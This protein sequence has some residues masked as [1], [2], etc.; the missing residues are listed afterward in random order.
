[1]KLDTLT[2]VKMITV[3]A[4]LILSGPAAA[5]ADHEEEEG[6]ASEG[7]STNESD[8]FGE[9]GDAEKPVVA[10]AAAKTKKASA[11]SAKAKESKKK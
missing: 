2:I 1:M 7:E 3:C 8:S 5:C 4:A 11:K 9:T 6:T 10:A